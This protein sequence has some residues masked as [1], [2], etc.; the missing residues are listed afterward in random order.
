MLDA[1]SGLVGGNSVGDNPR[2]Y[3]CD[4]QVYG[5]GVGSNR[6]PFDYGDGKAGA[7]RF[8]YTAKASRAERNTGLHHL[9]AQPAPGAVG[10]QAVT[11]KD[12]GDPDAKVYERTTAHQNTHPTVKPVALMRWLCRL[13]CPPGG[14]VLDPFIGSGSTAVAARAEGFRCIGIDQDLEYLQI[15]AGRLSQLSLFGGFAED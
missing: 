14:V 15:A 7:S 4:N 11:A 3:V 5:K 10:M 9:P 12:W 1:Q 8:F 2:S 6:P 13:A